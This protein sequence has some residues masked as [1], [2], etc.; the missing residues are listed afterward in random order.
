MSRNDG[1]EQAQTPKSWK[2]RSLEDLLLLPEQSSMPY[3]ELDEQNQ[4]I[5]SKYADPTLTTMSLER[6]EAV[7]DSAVQ[8]AVPSATP[9]QPT[10]SLNTVL[11]INPFLTRLPSTSDVKITSPSL[12][13]DEDEDMMRSGETFPVDYYYDDSQKMFCWP[14]QESTTTSQDAM[15][16]FDREFDDDLSEDEDEDEEEY[17][18]RINDDD[19]QIFD[20]RRPVSSFVDDER[21]E[22]AIVDDDDDEDDEE[23]DEDTFDE[24]TLYEGKARTSSVVCSN[25]QYM[26]VPSSAHISRDSTPDDSSATPQSLNQS[27]I[28]IPPLSKKKKVSSR[29]KSSSAASA[30]PASRKKYSPTPSVVA[31]SS[32]P[33]SAQEVHTCQLINPITN[34]PCYK[35]FSRPYDL[36]RH[37]KTIHASK[38]KVFRCLICIQ[39]QGA[40]GY[41]KTFS[42]GDALSRHVKVKHEL[43]GAEAQK[44]I[45]F[46]KENV[47]YAGA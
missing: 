45:Q 37:Q 47:E 14:L 21:R 34:E 36:I 19:S 2:N 28:P 5:F 15:S 4:S 16:I 39:Q 8:N 25:D 23:E 22:T 33:G 24:D 10:V 12:F 40:E 35:K 46:A 42:R 17:E 29:R 7:E 44:A 3:P 20:R 11:N 6:P 30:I 18:A 41:Q 27:T 26:T 31:T 9:V 38:K 13:Q 32:V 1:Q 43:S